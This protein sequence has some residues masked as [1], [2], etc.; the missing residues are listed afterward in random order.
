MSSNIQELHDKRVAVVAAMNLVHEYF[1]SISG[2]VS[3][4]MNEAFITWD[5]EV[6]VHQS[7]VGDNAK[8]ALMDTMTALIKAMKKELR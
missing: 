6:I 8:A 5:N 3:K 7:L 2:S 1:P 4:D